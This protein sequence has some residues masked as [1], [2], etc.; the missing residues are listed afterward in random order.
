[1]EKHKIKI[2]EFV[3][4]AHKVAYYGLVKCSSGN[5][6]ARLDDNLIAL[7]ASRTWLAELTEEQVTICDIHTGKCLNDKQP[8]IESTFHLGILKSKPRTNVVLH[9]Q[10]PYATAICCGKPQD[11]NYNIIIEVPFYI[12][13]P[14]IV[15]YLP[16][17]SNELA[18]AVIEKAEQHN[19]IIMKN[20]GL[21]TFGK[22]Y[23]DTIQRAVFFELACQIL[24]YQNNPQ[25]LT[26]S[27]VEA[28]RKASSV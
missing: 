23:D 22:D 25:P 17:G 1:M 12:G 26:L 27:A 8:T 6:S 15:D 24:I 3:Q 10:S 5:L 9:F 20:H 19:M 13:T 11:Y 28:L 4:A 2:K 18:K 21:T 14:G 7:S 16:A